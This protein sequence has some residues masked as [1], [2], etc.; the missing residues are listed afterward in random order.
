[1]LESKKMTGDGGPWVS[2]KGGVR[3]SGLCNGAPFRP[4]LLPGGAAM[5]VRPESA[6]RLG[7]LGT[8]AGMSP[9]AP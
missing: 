7:G 1:M 2:G 8:G 5:A 4:L 6:G 9:G 3:A